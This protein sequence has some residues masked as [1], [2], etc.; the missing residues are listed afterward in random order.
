MKWKKVNSQN[1]KD[2]IFLWLEAN[3]KCIIDKFS[4]VK[5]LGLK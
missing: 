4:A 2:G 5:K 1:D 3:G